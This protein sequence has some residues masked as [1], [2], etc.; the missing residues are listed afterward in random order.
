[1]ERLGVQD[2]SWVSL[3]KPE[4]HLLKLDIQVNSHG[5]HGTTRKKA[6]M[7]EHFPCYSVDSVAE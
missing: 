3:I 5:I 6:A 1:M 2:S 4:W 7:K